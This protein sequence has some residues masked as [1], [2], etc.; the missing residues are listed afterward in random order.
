MAEI[1]FLDRPQSDRNPIRHLRPYLS[2]LRF[3]ADDA[4]ALA[5]GLSGPGAA[6][7]W[8]VAPVLFRGEHDAGREDD[9]GVL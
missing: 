7:P 4:D 2:V 6:C 8:Q 1:H 9:P 3:F 5:V